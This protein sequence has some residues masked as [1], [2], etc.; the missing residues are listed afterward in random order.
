MGPSYFLI[1][2]LWGIYRSTLVLGQPWQT[3]ISVIKIVKK[4]NKWD[5]CHTQ[6]C[7]IL[8]REI[9]ITTNYLKL[10][11]LASSSKQFKIPS[12]VR[13]A[14]FFTVISSSHI[15]N[16]HLLIINNQKKKPWIFDVCLIHPIS[17]SSHRH[18]VVGVGRLVP[19][20]VCSFASNVFVV[21]VLGT[22]QNIP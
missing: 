5:G 10:V 22:S 11:C 8:V 3:Q 13:M 9:S 14:I 18:P 19:G 16:Q 17:Q 20:R 7:L 4:K 1:P 21:F 6:V 2:L 15:W 12:S